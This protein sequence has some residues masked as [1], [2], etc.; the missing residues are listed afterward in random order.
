MKQIQSI[1]LRGLIT[2]IPI[3]ITIYILY[4]VLSLVEN[5]LGG[6]IRRMMGAE[7]YYPGLGFSATLLLIFIFGLLL[8]NLITAGFIKNIEARMMAVPL[9]KAVYSPLRDLMNL[10]SKKSHDQNMK[11]VVLVDFG[12]QGIKAMG[13][14]T[15][16]SFSDVQGLSGF[17]GTHV[18][19]Y[20]PMSY[21]LGG[22]TFLVPKEKI[23]LIDVPIEKAMSLAITGWVKSENNP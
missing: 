20:F 2:F 8:N 1:F 9:I 19:V 3:A 4:T 11:S 23:Q 18:S 21:G 12:P 5:L 13:L 6:L 7:N 16:E 15:R 22:F 14:V 10:F 17:T